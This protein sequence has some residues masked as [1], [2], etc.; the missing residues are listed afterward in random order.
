MGDAIRDEMHPSSSFSVE[1]VEVLPVLPVQDDGGGDAGRADAGG[2]A[3][4]RGSGTEEGPGEGD[5]EQVGRRAMRKISV[6]LLPTTALAGVLL[7]L[8]NS[9][10]AFIASLLQADMGI[11][12]SG[13]GLLLSAYYAGSIVGQVPSSLVAKRM[14]MKVFL[15]LLYCIWA[16]LCLFT[17]AAPSLGALI[18]LRALVGALYSGMI[19]SLQAMMSQYYGKGS[20]GRA[21]SV[22][23]N[24]GTP[25]GSLLGGPVA[26]LVL[27]VTAGPGRWRWLFVVQASLFLLAAAPAYVVLPRGPES[28]GFLTAR[29]Q[30]W[31]ADQAED[32]QRDKRRRSA[33]LAAAS[34]SQWQVLRALLRDVRILLLA[35]TRLMRT[36]GVYG[37]MYWTPLIIS[38]GGRRSLTTVALLVSLMLAIA[39]VGAQLWAYSSDRRRE[40]IL[41]AAT[42]LFAMI[43]GLGATGLAIQLRPPPG[44]SLA[45]EVAFLTL[46]RV[47]MYMFVIPFQAFQSDILPKE[48]ANIGLAIVAMAG[49]LAGLCG[50]LVI[51]IIQTHFGIPV[52]LYFM[53]ATS[54]A[55]FASLLPLRRV[56]NTAGKIEN[57]LDPEAAPC[58]DAPRER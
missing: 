47:G 49:S 19:P 43:I 8:D 55:A 30:R 34:S 18:A 52:S 4:G 31:M 16:A 13:Y 32:V 45:L 7:M 22:S 41:H 57:D 53:A 11:S 26:A 27:H 40:R 25:L 42:G 33:D 24:L 1:S 39:I 17:A 6:R 3:G 20:I 12:T 37:M 9:N 5:E 38:D 58:I 50:P 46:A 48:A 51:G 21:W 56:Q 36:I 44:A 15:P 29:E 28:C 54:S 14:G 2:K 23:M 10:M 35:C